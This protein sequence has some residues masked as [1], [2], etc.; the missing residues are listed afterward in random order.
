MIVKD[1]NRAVHRNL[2]LFSCLKGVIWHA[3]CDEHRG[4]GKERLAAFCCRVNVGC[5]V[6]EGLQLGLCL[7]LLGTPLNFLVLFSCFQIF[8]FVQ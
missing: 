3:F 6:V 2:M 1:T 7:W 5:I 8:D 4:Q